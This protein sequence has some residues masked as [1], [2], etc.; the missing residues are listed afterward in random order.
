MQI[1][2][3]AYGQNE[4]VAYKIAWIVGAIRVLQTEMHRSNR[5][6]G[7]SVRRAGVLRDYFVRRRK[8]GHDDV[9]VPT[10]ANVLFSA[11]W[12]LKRR[13]PARP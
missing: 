6:P 1:R 8:P 3:K 9:R 13:S 12:M 2:R 5:Y 10:S 4:D 11:S 7:Y